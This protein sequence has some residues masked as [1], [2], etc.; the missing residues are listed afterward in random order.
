MNGQTNEAEKKPQDMKA[1]SPVPTQLVRIRPYSTAVRVPRKNLER[2]GY[3]RAHAD[4]AQQA[5]GEQPP[6]KDIEVKPPDSLRVLDCLAYLSGHKLPAY[7]FEGSNWMSML[8]NADYLQ[9]DELLTMCYQSFWNEWKTTIKNPSFKHTTIPIIHIEKILDIKT[10]PSSI[11]KAEVMLEWANAPNFRDQEPIYKLVRN[12]CT[13]A[14][15][16]RMGVRTLA[17]RFKD[18]LT[19]IVP[20]DTWLQMV[21]KRE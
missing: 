16:T 15:W 9:I 12:H 17:Q 6:I 8:R 19:Q 4:F 10:N 14:T 1:T 5:D 11:E 21:L 7:C 3:F 13:D 20:A 18:T 2:S